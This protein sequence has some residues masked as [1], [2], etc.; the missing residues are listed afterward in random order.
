VLQQ[1]V[2]LSPPV[3]FPLSY[4]LLS[5]LAG[6]PT[7]QG[8]DGDGAAAV[9]GHLWSPFAIWVSAG[10]DKY[11]TDLHACTVRKIDAATGHLS[12]ILGIPRDCGTGA[13]TGL[14]T[15][16]KLNKP[17]GLF[18]DNNGYLYVADAANNLI[19]K[20]ATASGNVVA[21]LD[22]TTFSGANDPLSFPTGLAYHTNSKFLYITEKDSSTVRKVHTDTLVSTEVY[23]DHVNGGD[24]SI[25]PVTMRRAKGVFVNRINTMVYVADT[26][27]RKIYSFSTATPSSRRRLDPA[28]TSVSTYFSAMMASLLPM[29]ASSDSTSVA[30]MYLAI[31]LVLCVFAAYFFM[32]QMNKKSVIA[33]ETEVPESSDKVVIEIDVI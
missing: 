8:Y 16:L 1:L 28:I 5:S 13:A 7:V 9:A 20:F 12:T 22:G 18:G 32:K 17:Y 25:V 29:A 27:D 19:R 21:S 24:G 10:G 2:S 3:V 31:F 14:G 30:H 6:V 33:E 11:F 23:A 15:T 26:L 4:S